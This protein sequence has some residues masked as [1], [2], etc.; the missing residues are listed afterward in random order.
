MRSLQQ[1]NRNAQAFLTG[2]VYLIEEDGEQTPGAGVT[3]IVITPGDEGEKADTTYAV[4]G[5]TG[6][7]S[8]RNLKAVESTVTFSLL[9]YQEQ[10]YPISLVSGQN[11]VIASLKADS[12]ALE[13]AIIKDVANPVSIKAD[14]IAFHASAVKLNKGEMAIDILE[15][16]PV[17]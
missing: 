7:F 14:T 16:M 9:G 10:T 8:I 11:R 1:A 13:G 17:N 15:Q 3:V 4:S 6:I 12:I 2:N 5:A